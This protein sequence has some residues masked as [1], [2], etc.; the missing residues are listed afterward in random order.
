MHYNGIDELELI[1]VCYLMALMVHDQVHQ[2]IFK[3]NFTDKLL[4]DKVVSSTPHH[5]QDLIHNFSVDRH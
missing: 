5:E 1:H 3:I 2:F 4:S